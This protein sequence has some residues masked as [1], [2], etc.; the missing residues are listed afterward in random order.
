MK[1]IYPLIA[2]IIQLTGK[3]IPAH[4][5][6]ATLSEPLYLLKKQLKKYSCYANYLI[7]KSVIKISLISLRI[8][9]YLRAK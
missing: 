5:L 9:F 8:P 1:E 3:H 4:E 2:I 7:L 6:H